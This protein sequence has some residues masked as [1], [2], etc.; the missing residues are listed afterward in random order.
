MQ[1]KTT[2]TRIRAVLAG[3]LLGTLISAAMVIGCHPEIGDTMRSPAIQVDEAATLSV[4]CADGLSF[5]GSAVVLG[6]DRLL[7][8][9]HVVACEG[10]GGAPLLVLVDIGA[11]S[12]TAIVELTSSGSDLARLVT[13]D[14]MEYHALLI[15][16]RPEV[17]DLLCVAAGAPAGRTRRCGPVE[18]FEPEPGD[19]VHAVV[20]E[21][22]NSGAGVYDA[23]GRLVGILSHYR[24]CVNGQLCGGK[25]TSLAGRAWVLAW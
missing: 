15:G 17:G 21:P 2:A 10:H 12:T 4:L 1:H 6:P 13:A 7:T 9:A 18:G 8:A 3:A 20:T 24:M 5:A 19:I 11:T 16:P 22:G 23:R 14:R 25:A